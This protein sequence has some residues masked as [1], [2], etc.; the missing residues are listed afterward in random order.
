LVAKD[1][2]TH[3]YTHT[4][5]R[6]YTHANNIYTHTTI[7]VEGQTYYFIH[8]SKVGVFQAG[9]SVSAKFSPE[10]DFPIKHCCMDR[11]A[12]ESKRRPKWHRDNFEIF[13]YL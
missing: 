12:R 9:G 8:L 11:W 1:T 7:Y 13:P 2:H 5:T 10:R 6:K 4:N 3:T